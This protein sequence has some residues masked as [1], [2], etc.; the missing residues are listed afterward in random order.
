[1]ILE[2]HPLLLE[3]SWTFKQ[4]PEWVLQALLYIRTLGEEN[5]DAIVKQ[6]GDNICSLLWESLAQVIRL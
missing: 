4:E 5:P 2:E 6:G 3:E 1:M